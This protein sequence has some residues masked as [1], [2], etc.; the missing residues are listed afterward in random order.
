MNSVNVPS[1]V[2]NIRFM[3]YSYFLRQNLRILSFVSLAFSAS[4]LPPPPQGTPL[5]SIAEKVDA[6]VFRFMRP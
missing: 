1:V 6:F 5:I 4:N 2:F 3:I